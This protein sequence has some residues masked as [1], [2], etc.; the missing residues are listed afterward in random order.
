MVSYYFMTENKVV[1]RSTLQ[2]YLVTVIVLEFLASE[3]FLGL[4]RGVFR[5]SFSTKWAEPPY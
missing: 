2:S 3:G 5:E 4:F 1:D